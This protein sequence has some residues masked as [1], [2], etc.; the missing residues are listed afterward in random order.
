MADVREQRIYCAE[1]I[2]VPPELP[3]ILKHYAK[4]VIRNK[5]GDVVDFSA[6]YFR[7][8]L[9]K[10]EYKLSHF[11]VFISLAYYESCQALSFLILSSK[12]LLSYSLLFYN[13]YQLG[14][15]G[16]IVCL[17]ILHDNQMIVS[18]SQ[19]KTIRF[20]SIKQLATV[21]ILRDFIEIISKITLS[22]NC[23]DMAVAMEDGSIRLFV[24]QFPEDIH[25]L[26]LDEINNQS[27]YVHCYKVFGRQCLISAKNCNLQGAVIEQDESGHQSR[28]EKRQELNKNYIY[29]LL[30]KYLILQLF[31]YFKYLFFSLLIW[32]NFGINTDY[33]CISNRHCSNEMQHILSQEGESQV[34]LF[35]CM[36]NTRISSQLLNVRQFIECLRGKQT[37]QIQPLI[38]CADENCL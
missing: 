17:S 3:V 35:Y 15:Q 11:L 21:Y 2:V 33:D 19:D 10:R 1:Q 31:M 14:H 23:K 4:E 13:L 28:Q 37:E 29:Q 32:I 34:V 22:P 24:L 20:W 18:G 16:K 27:D 5:P 8:L 9:E 38:R 12:C 6:K 36:R 26:K 30:Y 7:S 25:D